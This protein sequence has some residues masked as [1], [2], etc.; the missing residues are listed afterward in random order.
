MADNIKD[1]INYPDKI[2]VFVESVSMAI[3]NIYDENSPYDAVI[4]FIP[5]IDSYEFI[6]TE[7]L[8]ELGVAVHPYGAVIIP[9]YESLSEEEVTIKI[10]YKGTEYTTTDNLENFS[11]LGSYDFS[12]SGEPEGIK[13]LLSTTGSDKEVTYAPV[14]AIEGSNPV[15]GETSTVTFKSGGNGVTITLPTFELDGEQCS[16]MVMYDTVTITSPITGVGVLPS[17]NSTTIVQI[18]LE[19]YDGST[20]P[21]SVGGVG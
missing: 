9:D 18:A 6:Q 2:N 17:A 3:R 5:M 12:K 19:D 20:I 11:N 15:L 7:E 13:F 16:G 10:M 8:T 4:K 1:L 14:T 21:L